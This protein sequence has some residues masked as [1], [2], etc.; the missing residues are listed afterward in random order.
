VW[1]CGRAFLTDA[2]SAGWTSRCVS[3]AVSLLQDWVFSLPVYAF[4]CTGW[5]RVSHC[6]AVRPGI[7]AQIGKKI[8][9]SPVAGVN[10]MPLFICSGARCR[11]PFFGKGGLAATALSSRRVCRRRSSLHICCAAWQFVLQERDDLALVIK[12]WGRN[13][14]DFGYPVIGACLRHSGQWQSCHTLSLWWTADVFSGI[15]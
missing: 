2:I 4:G 14:A 12:N 5:P 10:R 7:T 15:S 6:A 11:N 3:A 13:N 9:P 8:A 1:R